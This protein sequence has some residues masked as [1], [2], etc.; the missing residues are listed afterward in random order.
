MPPLTLDPALEQR[1]VERAQQLARDPLD[2]FDELVRR[3][4]DAIERREIAERLAVGL[5]AVAIVEDEGIPP[6]QVFAEADALL[7]RGRDK[8]DSEP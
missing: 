2:L 1:I 7:E 4:L 8:P 6:E 3:G 5:G